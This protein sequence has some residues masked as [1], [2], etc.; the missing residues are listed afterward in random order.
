[1]M[2]EIRVFARVHAAGLEID[3]TFLFV[4][5]VNAPYDPL[6]FGDLLFDRTGCTVVEIEVVP[7]IPLRHPDDLFSV[8]N[9]MAIFFPGITEKRFRLFTNNRAGFPGSGVDLNDPVDLVT[10]LVV[11]EGKSSAVLPPD[12]IRH[13]VG[14]RKQIVVDVNLLFCLDM[15]KN[16]LFDVECVTRFGIFHVVI[17]RLELVVRRR[18]DILYDTVVAP[19]EAVGGQLLR[20]GRPGYRGI[21]VVVTFGSVMAQDEFF[22]PFFQP[23]TNIVILDESLPLIVRRRFGFLGSGLRSRTSFPHCKSPSA[24]LALGRPD[25]LAD[26][27]GQVAGIFPLPD[28]ELD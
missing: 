18:L 24:S 3:L 25:L 15:K 17:L 22:F 4:D 9:V 28:I 19:L 23:N 20:I 14:I 21:S 10:P 12:E 7:A 8:L 2:D 16:G 27:R 5:F 1:M 13:V 26:V 11:F 6:T